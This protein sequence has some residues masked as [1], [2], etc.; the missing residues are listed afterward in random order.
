M[1]KNQWY[2]YIFIPE[3]SFTCTTTYVRSLVCTTVDASVYTFLYW[4]GI[5]LLPWYNATLILHMV[6]CESLPCK[7]TTSWNSFWITMWGWGIHEG[8]LLRY[9]RGGQREYEHYG[10][11]ER[12]GMILMYWLKRITWVA[13]C[14]SSW[15]RSERA[16]LAGMET[17]MRKFERC[18]PQGMIVASAFSERE[19]GNT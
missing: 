2:N 8:E 14:F 18:L 11:D 12:G 4:W 15:N 1:K 9:Q 17:L 3:C 19:G 13:A 7:S 10:F 16:V 5:L 6:K